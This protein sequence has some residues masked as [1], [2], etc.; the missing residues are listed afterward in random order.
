MLS[1]NA[2]GDAA[3]GEMV[4]L[5]CFRYS[6]EIGGAIGEGRYFDDHPNKTENDSHDYL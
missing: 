3:Q 1:G 2:L 4:M 5:Y 6:W